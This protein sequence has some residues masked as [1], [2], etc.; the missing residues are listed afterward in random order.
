MDYRHFLDLVAEEL[1]YL[2]AFDL[3]FDLGQLKAAGSLA[4]LREYILD[5]LKQESVPADD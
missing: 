2:S 4:T 3:T 1:D 5:R